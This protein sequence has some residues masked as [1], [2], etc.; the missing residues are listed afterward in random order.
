MGFDSTRSRRIDTVRQTLR[1]R[2]A[3]AA[4]LL[5]MAGLCCA[6]APAAD[7]P[8]GEWPCVGRDPLGQRHSPLVQ[9]DRQNVRDLRVAW[10]YR[11]GELERITAPSLKVK[12]TFEATPLVIDGVMYFSTPTAR[13]IALDAASG[14]ELWTHD[15]HIKGFAFA[16]GASRGVSYWKSQTDPSLRRIFIGTLDARLVAV[17]AGTGQSCQDFGDGG[18][19]DLAAGIP[20]T[21]RGIYAVTSPPAIVGDAVIVGSAV[22]DNQRFDTSSGVVRAFDARSGKLLW[23]WDPI[24]RKPTDPGADTWR[25]DGALQ[26]GAANVWSIMSADPAR[27]LVFLPTTCPAPDFYGGRRLGDNLYANSVVALEAATGRRVWHYQVV[28]HDI[29]DYDIAAQPVLFDFK[30]DGITTPAVAVGT[31]M[32]HVFVLDRQTGTPL[33]PVEERA[34]PTSNVAGEE[35]SPTQPFPT[36]PALGLQ[37]A[38]PWGPDK[39]AEQWAAEQFKALRYEGIFTPPSVQGSILAPANVGGINWSGMTVDAGRQILVTNV[40]RLA[41]TVRLIPRDQ[42][43]GKSG[44]S[45]LGEELAAQRGTPF[46]MA[47]RTLVA[48]TTG[49]PATKPPW[50][51]LAAID[52][53]SRKLLWEVPLGYMVDPQTEPRAREWGSVNLGGAISTASGLVFVAA[54]RDGHF[55]AFDIDSGKILWEAELPAGGQATPMTYQVGGKQYVAICAGGHARL[56]TKLGDYVVAFALP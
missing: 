3:F 11:T 34:V 27:G 44:G 46:G 42:Y 10:T 50:G 48:P 19:I 36:L 16:E 35:T 25:G 28:H 52:L 38:E 33:I 41:T 6:S 1:R 43:G 20:N 21:T 30:R 24:P 17:D 22:G 2:A 23:S 45:R 55:R 54:S 32:G 15:P 40:N 37:Q 47:R 39:A 12:V 51:T 13:V 4:A 49:L 5:L 53:S 56:G 26:T 9:I 7:P 18:V 31:K 14:K 29:W 8:P